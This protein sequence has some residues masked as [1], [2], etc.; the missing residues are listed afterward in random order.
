MSVGDTLTIV[1]NLTDDPELR[2]TTGGV[3]MARFT[4]A[5]TPRT[6]DKTTGQWTDGTAL[7]LRATAWRELANNIAESLTKGMRVVVTGTLRQHNWKTDQGENR[8]MLGIDVEDIGPSLKF[9]TSKVTRAQRASSGQLAQ[10]AA[11][12]WSTAGPAPVGAT[13][14]GFGGEE[15]PF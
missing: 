10:A 7:F 4:I 1:G 2:F 11:D 12:P 9:A 8:S 15:P 13:A 5:S 14:G 3:A 6:F